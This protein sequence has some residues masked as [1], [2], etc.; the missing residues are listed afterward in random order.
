MFK[1]RLDER[2]TEPSNEF[3]T[4]IIVAF[5][6][7]LIGAI[8]MLIAN[9]G[10]GVILKDIKDWWED[11]KWKKAI[12]DKKKRY[13]EFIKDFGL[14]KFAHLIETI[15]GRTQI[16]YP[17]S[18]VKFEDEE[19]GGYYRFVAKNGS[20]PSCQLVD[21]KTLMLYIDRLYGAINE[22]VNIKLTD[23][24]DAKIKTISTKY[25][26]SP[27]KARR[28]SDTTMHLEPLDL[29]DAKFKNDIWFKWYARQNDLEKI[30]KYYPKCG[31]IHIA[32][33][34]LMKKTLNDDL[35]KL[36]EEDKEV[37]AKIL[38]FVKII[39]TLMT[40]LYNQVAPMVIGINAAIKQNVHV[41]RNQDDDDWAGSF[42]EG[43]EICL[44]PI[45][46]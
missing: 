29:H 9:G 11:R 2:T 38:M 14:G 44:E 42:G 24:V 7:G 1:Y 30:A 21:W 13:N 43:D 40:D 34:E 39:E 6:T 12:A 27:I 20:D 23:N 4:E 33:C 31:R 26:G 8:L 18:D 45:D 46:I 3:V 5:C 10:A 17:L 22:A 37:R 25:L 41:E 19:R 32:R 16:G 15:V 35:T 28:T 36:S